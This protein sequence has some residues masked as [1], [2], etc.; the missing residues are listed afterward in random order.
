MSL[1]VSSSCKSKL[2]FNLIAY[3]L[4]NYLTTIFELLNLLLSILTM[5]SN[6]TDKVICSFLKR[7]KYAK[8][9]KTE[10]KQR[11]YIAQQQQLQVVYKNYAKMIKMQ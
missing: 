1:T 7:K 4:K 10:K 9:I 3:F 5:G 11:F 8:E 6:T 2:I